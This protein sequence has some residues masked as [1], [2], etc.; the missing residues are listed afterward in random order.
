[1]RFAV[2]KFFLG[3]PCPIVLYAKFH[4]VT[5]L[6]DGYLYP[7]GARVLDDIIQSLLKDAVDAD[8][9]FYGEQALDVVLFYGDFGAFILAELIEEMIQGHSEPQV[10]QGGPPGEAV[11]FQ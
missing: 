2:S 9:G 10:I 11:I 6:L 8:L 3:K 4:A 5:M 1:M 7:C